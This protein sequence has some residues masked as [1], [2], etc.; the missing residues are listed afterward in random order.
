MTELRTGI[1]RMRTAV[2]SFIEE[3]VPFLCERVYIISLQ[4]SSYT[5]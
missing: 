4:T 5:I 1:L 3:G 2:A